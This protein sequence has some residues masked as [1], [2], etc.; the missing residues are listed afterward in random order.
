MRQAISPQ[1]QQLRTQFNELR[2]KHP[3]LRIRNAAHALGVSEMDLVAAG[4]GDIESSLLRGPAQEIFRELGSLGRVMAL[5]RND[6][7]VHDRHGQYLD[8]HAGE[9]MGIVLGPDIDLRMFFTCWDSTWAV[10]DGGRHSIQFFDSAGTAVHKVFCTDHSDMQAYRDL[11]DRF[12]AADPKW[13]RTRPVP[14][15][16]NAASTTDPDGLRERWLATKDVHETHGILKKFNVT[17]LGALKA[18]GHDLAQKLDNEIAER[19]LHDVAE[20][21]TSIMCFVGNHGMVQIHSGPVK[22]LVR[23]GPW[24]NILDPDFNLHLDTTAIAQ[25]WIV[26]RPSSDGWIT[27]LECFAANGDLI[28]QF[29][30]ARKPGIPELVEWRR[31][32]VGYCPLPLAA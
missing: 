12:A 4:A 6:W 13:P 5:T 10:N 23:T 19:M 2:S 14:V 25:T 17:R 30:G 8:I 24:F 22:K 27:S 18:L 20:P 3:K 29:F 21:G 16:E 7:C 32:L 28:A 1:A 11:I 31:L 9:K 15:A 26:N